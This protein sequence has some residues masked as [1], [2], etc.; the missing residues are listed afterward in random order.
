LPN[1]GDAAGN[2]C[3]RK[4][5]PQLH[6]QPRNSG[7]CC[8]TSGTINTSFTV[9]YY[10]PHELARAPNH[11]N[12]AH[13]KHTKTQPHTQHTSHNS[14]IIPPPYTCRHTLIAFHTSSYSQSRHTIATPTHHRHTNPTQTHMLTNTPHSPKDD[15][16]PHTHP[17]T[18]PFPLPCRNPAGPHA[19]TALHS[20]P[21]RHRLGASS[22]QRD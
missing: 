9:Y 16:A 11:A 1:G 20:T 18:I 2:S 13:Q 5:N 22:C 21:L 4:S 17:Q 8:A 15:L 7:P 6:K 14:P 10:Y 19:H 3:A 12:T